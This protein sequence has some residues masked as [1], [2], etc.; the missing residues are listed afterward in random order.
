MEYRLSKRA[1]AAKDSADEISFC[2]DEL[3]QEI[4]DL[5]EAKQKAESELEDAK[6][7]IGELKNEIEDLNEQL[8]D[9]ERSE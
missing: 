7:T 1:A 5:E 6:D 3:I 9:A 4:E 2:I 8:K